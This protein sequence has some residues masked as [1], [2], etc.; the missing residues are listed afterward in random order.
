M[1]VRSF[2]RSLSRPQR[3]REHRRFKETTLSLAADP[4][5][6]TFTSELERSTFEHGV[7]SRSVPRV[8]FK[9]V[10][11]QCHKEKTVQANTHRSRNEK[12]NT[13]KRVTGRKASRRRRL[14]NV[15]G[16]RSTSRTVEGRIPEAQEENRRKRNL[17]DAVI[18]G[19]EGERTI[20]LPLICFGTVK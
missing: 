8:F 19:G 10:H 5:Q 3:P 17:D 7:Q 15:P 6:A 16:L 12:Q 2:C 4:L 13:S 11:S 9:G 14:K 18:F 1:I 20:R